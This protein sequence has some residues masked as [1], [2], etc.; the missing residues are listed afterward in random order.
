MKWEN[1]VRQLIIFIL[2]TVEVFIGLRVLLRLLGA[3]PL[4]PLANW[5]YQ[6]SG[7]ILYPFAG[8]FPS[9]RLTQSSVLETSSLFA[10]FF[11]AVSAYFVF[12]A[13]A[14]FL[15]WT[16]GIMD[17]FE[18]RPLRS[19]NPLGQETKREERETKPL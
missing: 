9:W 3:N 15:G 13:L 18:K 1:T 19:P 14:I 4:A 6:V 2:G 10:M 11:Y 17:I 16:H 12:E 8:M 7:W 5:V